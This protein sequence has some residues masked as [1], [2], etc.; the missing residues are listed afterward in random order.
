M[1]TS[2]PFSFTLPQ[3]FLEQADQ[4]DA[5]HLNSKDPLLHQFSSSLS[6][7]SLAPEDLLSIHSACENRPQSAVF[8]DLWRTALDIT[9]GLDAVDERLLL[10]PEERT[11]ALICL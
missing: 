4:L 8:R 5:L 7:Y 6:S 3:S 9:T 2:R 1:A 10:C 11:L